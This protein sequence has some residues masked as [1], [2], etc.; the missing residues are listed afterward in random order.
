MEMDKERM[1]LDPDMETALMVFETYNA[2]GQVSNKIADWLRE[3][4]Y[5]AQAGH[6]RRAWLYTRQWPKPPGWAGTA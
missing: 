2:L 4:S 1:D 6:P 3:R 5:A